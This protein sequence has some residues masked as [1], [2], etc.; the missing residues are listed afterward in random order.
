MLLSQQQVDKI[1]EQSIRM[2]K[3]GQISE[4]VLQLI[5]DHR[6]FH[7]FVP[8]EL[9]GRMTSLPDA[10]RIFQECSRIDGNMG[11]LVTI[12]AGGGFFA[13]FMR[14]DIS[15]KVY[16]HRNAVIA[17]SGM[18]TGTARRVEGGFIVDG[19]W[20]YC[21]GSTHATVFTANVIVEP[22]E[23]HVEALSDGS[24]VIRS[25]ILWP[26]Q[27]HIDP[28][29]NAFGLKA[30]SSHQISAINAFVP[31]EM[32]FDITEIQAYENEMIYKY[33]F[34]PFAQASFATVTLGIAQHF[35]EAAEEMLAQKPSHPYLEKHLTTLHTNLKRSETAFY[36][37][38]TQSWDRL[39]KEGR[40][41]PEQ[42]SAVSEQ[43]ISMAEM[44]LR[45]G[46]DLFPLLGLSA[47]MENTTVN[48]TWRDLQT[49]C[50]HALLRSYRS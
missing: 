6:L 7:L 1:R 40:L 29:W 49:A 47:A 30:T 18:P 2:E 43:C 17:G 31:Y 46:Q 33:P 11:W 13:S 4:E 22:D 15:R 27:I 21:S 34:L 5:Y 32:T 8:N 23:E 48:R 42:E 39:L 24:P 26:E 16:A 25:M 9:E 19:S 38:I 28:D 35:L 44:S 12:G 36:S 20:K 37:C 10:V 41:L 50:Q 14:P 3:D 45:C